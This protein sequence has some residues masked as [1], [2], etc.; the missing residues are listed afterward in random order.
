MVDDDTSTHSLRHILARTIPRSNGNPRVELHLLR[1]DATDD[2]NK[3]IGLAA[4]LDARARSIKCRVPLTFGS[5]DESARLKSSRHAL[6]MIIVTES[7]ISPYVRSSSDRFG[8]A[9]SPST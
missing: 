4:H 7:R 9:A 8:R 3:N 2:V 5:N 6:W 1:E